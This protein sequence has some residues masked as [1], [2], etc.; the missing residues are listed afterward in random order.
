MTTFTCCPECGRGF[1]FPSDENHMYCS[2]ECIASAAQLHEY[3][4]VRWCFEGCETYDGFTDGTHWNGWLNVEVS[5][6]VH[7]LVCEDIR[8]QIA[9]IN[10]DPEDCGLTDFLEMV[11]NERGRYSYAYGYCAEEV[12]S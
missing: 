5:P 7:A 6:E 8:D 12:T 9:S 11:P 2:P 10:G 3:R 4:P 1:R